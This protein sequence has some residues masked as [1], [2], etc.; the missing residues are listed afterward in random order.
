[1]KSARKLAMGFGS[2]PF[3][4][5]LRFWWRLNPIY[6]PQQHEELTCVNSESNR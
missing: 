4:L 3:G 5:A 1:M 6:H 2:R